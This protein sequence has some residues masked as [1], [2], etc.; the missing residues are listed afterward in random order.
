M[1]CCSVRDDSRMQLH[2]FVLDV[3]AECVLGVGWSA[4]QQYLS[5]VLVAKTLSVSDCVWWLAQLSAASWFQCSVL[6][7]QAGE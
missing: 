1:V 4:A 5:C 6:V 2:A 3:S 7:D